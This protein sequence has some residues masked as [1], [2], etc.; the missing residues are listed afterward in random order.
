MSEM[1]THRHTKFLRKLHGV[2]IFYPVFSFLGVVKMVGS[3][4]NSLDFWFS[5]GTRNGQSRQI[6]RDVHPPTYQI[7]AKIAWL[8]NFLSSIFLPRCCLNG[9]LYHITAWISGFQ[10]ALR[11]GRVVRLSEMYTLGHTKFLPKLHGWVIFYPVFSFP[12]VVKMVG[13]VK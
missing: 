2:V 4:N 12:G 13:S 6:V 10:V 7:F 9:R 1:Y 5:G 8:G 11:I 3:A